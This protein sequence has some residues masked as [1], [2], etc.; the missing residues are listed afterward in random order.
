MELDDYV[1]YCFGLVSGANNPHFRAPLK[2]ENFWL[3]L[4]ADGLGAKYF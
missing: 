3:T 1:L 2:F 4:F